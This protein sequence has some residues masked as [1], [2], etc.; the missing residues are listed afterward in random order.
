MGNAPQEVKQKADWVTR[1]N[2][3]QGV[4]YMIKEYFRMQQ[5]KGFLKKFHIKKV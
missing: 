2:D 4:A 1:S 5:S 3:E